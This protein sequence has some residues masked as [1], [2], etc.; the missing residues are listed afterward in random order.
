MTEGVAARS[1]IADSTV[2]RRAFLSGVSN[3][4]DAASGLKEYWSPRVIAELGIKAAAQVVGNGPDGLVQFGAFCILGAGH[5]LFVR[6]WGVGDI[7]AARWD[8]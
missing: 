8:P 2:R 7:C 5:G 6:S 1:Q 3:P 4:V